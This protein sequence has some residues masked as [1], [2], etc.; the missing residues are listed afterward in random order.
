MKK[1]YIIPAVILIAVILSFFLFSSQGEESQDILIAV[2]KGNFE[3]TVNTSG[4]LI[5][6]NSVS[7]RGPM[8]LR[9][10]GIREVKI[11]KLVLEGTVVKEGD[12][13]ADLDKSELY[14][15]LVEE[16]DELT[17]QDAQFTQTQLDT[18]LTLREARDEIL[19]L[20][21]SVEEKKIALEQSAFE[22]P[23]T[24]KQAEIELDKAK[25]DLRQA[26]E[27]YK[28][29]VEQS[30]A[31]M[32]EAYIN[33]TKQRG[34]VKFMEDL[35]SS[36]TIKAPQGGMVI[37][38]RSWNGNKIREGSSIST[39]NPE[40][41]TLPD[42]STMLSKTYI[43]EIDIMKIKKKQHVKIGLDAFPDKKLS[44]EVIEVANVGEQKPNS[45]AK[46]FEV[47]IK[48]NEADTTLR[49]AMTTSNLIIADVVEDVLFVPLECLHNQGDSIT[50][51]YKKNGLNTVKQEVLVDKTNDDEAVIV[52][53]VKEND[54]LFLSIPN[55]FEDESVVRLE[56]KAQIARKE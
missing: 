56:R 6:V 26:N 31:K 3:I 35:L 36:F 50:Y 23:A 7:I 14:N 11:N 55:G 42:L 48:V 46:V 33:L 22:P 29:Q 27:N 4:E 18:A 39:W 25:R 8:G 1:R 52:Q 44:G 32:T 9:Q 15:K 17:K 38:T 21:Y 16:K 12:F 5:P 54:N 24:I 28:I 53:G 47:T 41:A 45:D 2:K 34:D 13:I 20:E 43:N 30:K 49:P 37:Y 10:S 40:V 19:N 51:V